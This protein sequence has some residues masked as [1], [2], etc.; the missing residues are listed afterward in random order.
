MP[1][2][3]SPDHPPIQGT[4]RQRFA[5]AA[6]LEPG[7]RVRHPQHPEWGAGQVQ[8]VDGARVTA[9]FEHVGKVLVNAAV[10]ALEPLD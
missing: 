10:V 5:G 3:K 8:S 1:M 6:M 4:G 9:N 7:T 2:S